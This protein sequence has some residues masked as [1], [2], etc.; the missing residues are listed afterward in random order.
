MIEGEEVIPVF[1]ASGLSK[2]NAHEPINPP[3]RPLGALPG[4]LKFPN[5]GHCDTGPGQTVKDPFVRQSWQGQQEKRESGFWSHNHPDASS[6]EL[7][8]PPTGENTF[9]RWSLIVSLI[10]P[11]CICPHNS[12]INYTAQINNPYYIASQKVL[13]RPLT[14]DVT[15]YFIF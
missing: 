8:R 5:P 9:G 3:I 6:S 4:A 11:L 7:L 13:Q 14:F 1:P 12:L 2:G 15:K 10:C